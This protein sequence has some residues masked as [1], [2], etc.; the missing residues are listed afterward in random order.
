MNMNTDRRKL[1]DGAEARI[2]A[3]G[4]RAWPV[5]IRVGRLPTRFGIV[6]VHHHIEAADVTYNLVGEPA[7][8]DDIIVEAPDG[9]VVTAGV[10]SQLIAACD[11][12][13]LRIVA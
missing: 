2:A 4:V 6:T 5:A 3:A 1:K 11:G 7:S 10:A 8:I 9:V 13:A 12:L